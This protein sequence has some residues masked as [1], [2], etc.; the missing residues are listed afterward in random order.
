M[1]GGAPI[2]LDAGPTRRLRLSPGEHRRLRRRARL[3]R[4][5]TAWMFLGPF[6]LFFVVFLVVPVVGTVWWSTRSGGITN[7]TVSV[8][9]DNFGRL[10]DL[11]GATT[12]IQNTLVF[13]LLSVP[14]ILV[15]ALA[16]ALVLAKVQRGASVYRFLV[17][18]PVLVPGVVAALIWLFLTNVDFGLFNEVL[19]TFGGKPVTWL[20]ASSALPVLAALDVWRNVGYWAIFFVAALIGLPQELYQAA[21]L[22]GA[23]GPARFRHLTLPLLRRILLF[24]V[25]VSTIWGLQVF[26]TALVL[27]AG[28]PGTSTTTIIY[29]VWQYVFAATDKVGFAAAISLVLIAAI[30][31]LTIVQLR[32]LRARRGGD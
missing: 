10:P 26:D 3:R 5:L 1:A 14:P 32:L 21:E 7:G 2:A 23:S 31:T 17:Y 30:L 28:G 11:V 22:D 8:G 29:R 16:I 20:G 13:A 4:E 6:F 27:T 15:G 25:V 12:A 24:A 18:F 9:L 19:R